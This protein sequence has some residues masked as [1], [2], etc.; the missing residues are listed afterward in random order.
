MQCMLY[1]CDHIGIEIGFPMVG[2]LMISPLQVK[3]DTNDVK[4][5]IAQLTYDRVLGRCN[6]AFR[7]ETV[8]RG[9]AVKPQKTH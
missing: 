7:W 4:R 1:T 5:R 3:P 8:S 6:I 9:D 2:G